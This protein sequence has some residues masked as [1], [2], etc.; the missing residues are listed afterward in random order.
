[1]KYHI[2][3][4]DVSLAIAI[5]L[6]H[7]I[8]LTITKLYHLPK[9]NKTEATYFDQ[10]Y[11]NI[12]IWNLTVSNDSVTTTSK[13]RFFVCYDSR[14]LKPNALGHIILSRTMLNSHVFQNLSRGIHRQHGNIL[15]ILCLLNEDLRL[16]KMP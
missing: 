8:M 13:I 10:V 14:K 7:Q 15:C 1:M 4:S 5:K 11:Y 2:L 12:T 9:L 6:E 16:T 3:S